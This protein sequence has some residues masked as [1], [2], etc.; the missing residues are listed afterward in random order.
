V[1]A[2][3]LK[4]VAAAEPKRIA[5]FPNLPA[6]NETVPGV[7]TTIWVGVFAPADT[8]KEIR[9]RLLAAIA[10]ALKQPEVLAKMAS[11]G[12]KP[13]LQTPD[14]FDAT[15]VKDLAFWKAVIEKAGM[16]KW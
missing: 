15:A 8:P 6:I 13:T 1:H 3:D 9:L 12:L 7:E 4:P 16:E 11:V 5:E 14:E 2:G 10:E